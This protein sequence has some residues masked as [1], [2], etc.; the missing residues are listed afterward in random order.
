MTY[1]E[2]IDLF[3]GARFVRVEGDSIY[4]WFGGPTIQICSKEEDGELLQ[5]S[6]AFT[7]YPC[8]KK[9]GSRHPTYLEVHDAVMEHIAEERQANCEECGG[10]GGVEAMACGTSA[11]S[12]DG[13]SG[14]CTEFFRCD[15]CQGEPEEPDYDSMREDREDLNAEVEWE[16]PQ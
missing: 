6:D 11:C 12:C 4:L 2:L 8:D 14:G 15:N 3:D 5:P 7:L 10:E 9:E 13:F 16:S 1:E